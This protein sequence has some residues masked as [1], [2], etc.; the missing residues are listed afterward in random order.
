MST[1]MVVTASVIRACSYS[2][3]AERG[4]T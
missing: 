3:L 2:K 4:G 1:S